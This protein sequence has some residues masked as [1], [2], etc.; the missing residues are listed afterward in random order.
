MKNGA[1]EFFMGLLIGC[2]AGGLTNEVLAT[3]RE[4]R[5]KNEAVSLNYGQWGINTNNSTVEFQWI[6][7]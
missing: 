7:K 5:L 1:I 4:R 2:L 6:Q 3:K